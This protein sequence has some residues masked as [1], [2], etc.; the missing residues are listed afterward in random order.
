MR[1]GGGTLCEFESWAARYTVVVR[2]SFG[3]RRFVTGDA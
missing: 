1:P 2:G 3:V